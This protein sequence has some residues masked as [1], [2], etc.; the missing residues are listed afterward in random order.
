MWV[1]EH[2][3]V[4]EGTFWCGRANILVWV[5]EHLNVGDILMW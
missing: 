3:G 1:R 2:F 5:S 4:G